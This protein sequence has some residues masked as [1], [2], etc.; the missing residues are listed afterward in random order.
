M[1]SADPRSPLAKAIRELRTKRG[2]TQ[3][4]LAHGAG[5]TVGHL[6]KIERGLAN[7]G[8]STVEAI[9]DALGVKMAEIVR[10]VEKHR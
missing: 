4:D 10:R 9:A 6:S 2:I 7:P 8:W 5:I 1:A 3:E